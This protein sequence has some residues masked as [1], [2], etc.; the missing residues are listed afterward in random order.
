MIL[1]KKNK[2]LKSVEKKLGC[3]HKYKELEKLNNIEEL[4]IEEENLGELFLNPLSKSYKFEQLTGNKS[5]LFSARLNQKVRVIFKPSC[6]QPYE[7]Q[8]IIEIEMIEIDDKHYGD[9]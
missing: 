5:S 4:L 8:N 7:Y 2:Y 9:G 3:S 1:N 6:D